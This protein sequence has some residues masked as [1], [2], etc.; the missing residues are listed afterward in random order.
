MMAEDEEE[1]RWQGFPVT[2]R[3]GKGRGTEEDEWE[4]D[5][6]RSELQRDSLTVRSKTG[7]R[8]PNLRK[9]WWRRLGD[10]RG[11]TTGARQRTWRGDSNG[12][13]NAGGG[14]PAVT[15]HLIESL[16]RPAASTAKFDEMKAIPTVEL[17][18]FGKGR[19]DED[20]DMEGTAYKGQRR[21]AV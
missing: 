18:G 21:R 17:W 1:V 7:W 13:A 16:R 12:G 2:E 4:H 10:L 14:A 5:L 20:F 11:M 9:R 8:R 15:E 3:E 19:R 6:T